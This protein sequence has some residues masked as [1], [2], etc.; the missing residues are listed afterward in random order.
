MEINSL[1]YSAWY[2]CESVQRK[3]LHPSAC[4][5]V[6]SFPLLP[7]S[8]GPRL[9]TS[10][11]Q[12]PY[13]RTLSASP[14]RER[15]IFVRVKLC[16]AGS[17]FSFAKGL[18]FSRQEVNGPCFGLFGVGKVATAIHQEVA[19]AGRRARTSPRMLVTV[20]A[21]RVFPP[22]LQAPSRIDYRHYHKQLAAQGLEH[23]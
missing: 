12:F 18:R 8:W 17:N 21:A 15:F 4:D 2:R 7:V 23:Q 10:L 5:H 9:K 1:R 14:Y 20:T 3:A 11:H 22:R 6:C 19:A 13:P 16:E